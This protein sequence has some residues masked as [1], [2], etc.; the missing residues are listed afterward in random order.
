[1]EGSWDKMVSGEA[2]R[3]TSTKGAAKRGYVALSRYRV[4]QTKHG[5]AGL[6]I[7]FGMIPQ[8]RHFITEVLRVP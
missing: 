3:G 5:E 4:A 2:R 1:V 7:H 6:R 8:V